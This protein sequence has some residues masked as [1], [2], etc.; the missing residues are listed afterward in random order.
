MLTLIQKVDSYFKSIRKLQD[1]TLQEI[2][3]T[4]VDRLSVMS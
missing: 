4:L 3:D 2:E 1:G